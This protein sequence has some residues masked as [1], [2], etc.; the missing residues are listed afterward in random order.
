MRY[1]L[2]LLFVFFFDLFAGSNPCGKLFKLNPSV[3]PNP[4]VENITNVCAG[5]QTC[6][7]NDEWQC[8]NQ[9]F[10][11]WSTPV[12]TVP[13]GSGYKWDATRTTYY[14]TTVTLCPDG[15]EPNALN[16][17]ETPPPPPICTWVVQPPWI[18]SLFN[19]S[20]CHNGNKGTGPNT[21]HLSYLWNFR[22]CEANQK[23]YGLEYY[24]P[25]GQIWD[26]TNKICREPKPVLP[27]CGSCGMFKVPGSV[28][29]SLLKTCFIDYICKCDQ[30]VRTRVEVSCAFGPLEDDPQDPNHP[31]EDPTPPPHEDDIDHSAMCGTLAMSAKASCQP[32]KILNFKCD[33]KTGSAVSTC[34]DPIVPEPTP[35][36]E[37]DRTNSSTSADIKEL[38]NYLPTAIRDALKDYLTDGSHPYLSKISGILDSQLT[39]D[40]ERND[41]LKAISE[42]TDASLKIQRDINENIASQKSSLDSMNSS[43]N[44]IES[45]LND[46]KTDQPFNGFQDNNNFQNPNDSSNLSVLDDI[47]NFSNQ[48]V[49]DATSI[50]T[51]FDEAK[52]SIQ[53][54]FQPVLLP[55]GGCLDITFTIPGSSTTNT[56]PLSRVPS[57]ISPYSPIFSLLVY[58]S[59]MF[60]IFKFLF[61]F[62]ISRSK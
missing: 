61:L 10:I 9:K 17:C 22:W 7:V 58:M 53:N 18:T 6:T 46:G 28:E 8:S 21:D 54:G 24:C 29:G 51:Q 60:F 52:S 43:L 57:L 32:P 40:S 16:V 62:F 15:T 56:I 41:R 11:D 49:N 13:Y 4:L 48:I 12:K 20:K 42:S 3:N 1:L 14:L 19:E 26:A 33:P 47:K 55:S 23:C 36:T 44:N 37:D 35:V 39:L 59:V 5:T 2:P 50:S 31:S 38:G 45:S 27:D 30:S 34:S 25:K